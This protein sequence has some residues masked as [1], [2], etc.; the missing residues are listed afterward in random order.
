MSSQM[1]ADAQAIAEMLNVAT[2]M[3]R[4]RGAVHASTEWCILDSMQSHRKR[5]WVT[6]VRASAIVLADIY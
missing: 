4:R 2:V 6:P 5:E 3:C 1:S